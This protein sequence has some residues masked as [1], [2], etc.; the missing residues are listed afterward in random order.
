[1]KTLNEILENIKNDFVVKRKLDT[2]FKEKFY[3][4]IV[5]VLTILGA[6]SSETKLKIDDDYR[7]WVEV[8]I[9]DDDSTSAQITSLYVHNGIIYGDIYGYYYGAE[10][11][12]VN[13]S[14]VVYSNDFQ[15]IASDLEFYLTSDVYKKKQ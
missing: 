10:M 13:I 8:S 3:N 5:D 7:T 4:Q 2:F 6:T 9:F 11:H 1:M 14:R 12:D 15:N